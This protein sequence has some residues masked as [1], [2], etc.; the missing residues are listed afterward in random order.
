MTFKHYNNDNPNEL[1]V[2]TTSQQKSTVWY[3]VFRLKT[4]YK[5]DEIK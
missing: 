4:D 3:P 5:P 1:I 2:I